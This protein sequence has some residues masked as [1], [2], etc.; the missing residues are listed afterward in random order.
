MMTVLFSMATAAFAADLYTVGQKVEVRE[1][2]TW[3]PASILAHEGRKYQ[4]HYTGDNSSDDEWVTTDRIRLPGTAA[5]NPPVTPATPDQPVDKYNGLKVDDKIEVKWGGTWRKAQ[6]IKQSNGWEMVQYIPGSSLEWIQPWRARS[7]GASYDIAYV[8]PREPVSK[9]T[10][11]PDQAPYAAPP[12]TPAPG[13]TPTPSPPLRRPRHPVVDPTPAALSTPAPSAPS[14]GDAAATPTDS[15]V[16]PLTKP[17]LSAGR[18]LEPITVEET[19]AP[20]FPISAIAPKLISLHHGPPAFG[21]KSEMFNHPQGKYSLLGWS[22]GE[23][24][25]PTS[26]QRIDLVGSDAGKVIALAN[27]DYPLAISP[28]GK[29]L[30]TRSARSDLNDMW[31]VDLWD[32]ESQTPKMILS[33]RAYDTG[34]AQ[35]DAV[36]M[37][38]FADNTHLLTSSAAHMVT[39]WEIGPDSVKEIYSV[40]SDGTV[41]PQLSGGGRYIIL[42]YDATVTMI[43]ILTGKCVAKAPAMT[44][45]NTWVC[46]LRGDAKKLALLGQRR[47]IIIDLEAGKITLDL[48]LPENL[49]GQHVSWLGQNMVLI[50][51]HYAFDV[52]RLAPVWDYGEPAM[53]RFGM[54]PTGELMGDHFWCIRESNG[55]A[56]EGRG[57][58]FM[59]SFLLPDA[60]AAAA[61]RTV[62]DGLQLVGPGTKISLEVNYSGSDDD[63]KKIVD[64]FTRELTANGVEVADGQ[65]VKL[66]CETKT[67]KSET[68]TYRF[69]GNRGDETVTATQTI[70]RVAFEADGK[71]LWA[72]TSVT[73]GY[74]PW[75]VFVK[76]GQSAADALANENKP[77]LNFFLQT[78]IPAVIIKPADPVGQSPFGASPTGGRV[79]N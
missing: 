48:G 39:L 40:Q 56:D 7:E 16:L 4:I 10:P 72:M 17:D 24:A 60:R 19:I 51:Y 21:T 58:S 28:D 47:M 30:A 43:D 77:Q 34:T 12:G 64:R 3:S 79:R 75:T 46:G 59:T 76:K 18:D 1:G 36:P 29:R 2:D 5:S 27:H 44:D 42:G 22:P 62:A 31:R 50:D 68:E 65:S 9:N 66:I 55:S 71:E 63:K 53:Y 8:S 11:A 54:V 49:F 33:F 73:G 67:G 45:I 14:P 78:H 20:D 37:A 38:F 70:Y 15:V 23:E 61:D 32:I 6:I 57:R 52:D 74:L 69:G 13:V 41:V 26:I 25:K 35:T